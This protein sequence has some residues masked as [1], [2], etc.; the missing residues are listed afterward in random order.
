M[1]EENFNP[2]FPFAGLR[3]LEVAQG[4]AAPGA[5]ALLAAYGADVVKVEGLE[6]DWARYL[7]RQFDG[8]CATFVANNRGKR[9]LA[10]DMRSPEGRALLGRLARQADVVLENFRPG[11]VEKLG[12]GYDAVAKE[13]PGCV[14]VSL[15]GFG[16]QGPYR[17]RAATDSIVQALS[18]LIH[19]N[20]GCDDQPHKVEIPAV[21]LAA[22]THAFQAIAVALYGREKTGRG[23]HIPV[24]LLQAAAMLQAGRIVEDVVTGGNPPRQL[25]VPS[26]VFS[27][28][29]GRIVVVT[30]N[31]NQFRRLCGLLGETALAGDARFASEEGRIAN[32]EDLVACLEKRFSEKTAE[33]WSA[34][35]EGG[36]ILCARVNNHGEF[37]DDPQVKAADVFVWTDQPGM[38]RI[39]L[40]Q[41]IGAA[42]LSCNAPQTRTPRL[43]EHS[44]AV[45]SE[46]GLDDSE[47]VRLHA[48]GIVRSPDVT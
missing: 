6:G 40:A 18:G 10:L 17:D 4:I 41:V 8:L 20:R 31:N 14:Y 29:A 16:A 42:Q 26:N 46:L 34:L 3:V 13:N 43:G 27:T 45:L 47:I 25:T 7:G 2:D 33:E 11:I 19:T 44:R 28:K 23:R 36:D 48:D 32:E 1:I 12:I 37:L 30:L 35:L 5:G 9:A 39:P 22:A 24:T 38:G 21:D 15:T